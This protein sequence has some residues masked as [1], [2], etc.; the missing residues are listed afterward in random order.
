MLKRIVSLA[1]ARRRIGGPQRPSGPAEV[2]RPTRSSALGVHVVIGD[3]DRVFEFANVLRVRDRKLRDERQCNGTDVSHGS[4][5]NLGAVL[6]L[7]KDCRQWEPQ[8][9]PQAER[10]EYGIAISTFRAALVLREN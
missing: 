6:R 8:G 1:Q 10:A 7:S 2:Y 5:T 9:T 4:N 3:D